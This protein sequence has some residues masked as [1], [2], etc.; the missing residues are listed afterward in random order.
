MRRQISAVAVGAL[1]AVAGFAP[2]AR[3]QGGMTSPEQPTEEIAR[4]AREPI[5]EPGQFFGLDNFALSA[6][7]GATGFTENGTRDLADTGLQWTVRGT[8][9]VDR[10]FGLEAAYVGVSQDLD[11]NGTDAGSVVKTGFEALARLGVPFTRQGAPAGARPT[12]ILPYF[13]AGLGWNLL[14]LT[15]GAT[16]SGFGLEDNDG[17]FTIPLALGVSGGMRD[18]LLDA[19]LTFRPSFADDMFRGVPGGAGQNDLS[20]TVVAGYRF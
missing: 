12:F 19:R 20:G 13:A 4:A 9:G 11:L 2:D 15:E 14:T 5:R 6:G 7:F 8:F 10:A 1:A 17:S 3:A 18:F 16:A